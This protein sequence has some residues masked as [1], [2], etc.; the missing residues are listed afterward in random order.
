MNKNIKLVTATASI[1]LAVSL[2]LAGCTGAPATN[3]SPKPSATSSTAPS[4]SP[5]AS[6]APKPGVNPADLKA[7][8][9]VDNSTA[10]D[11]NTSDDRTIH[12]YK[13]PNGSYAV[14]KTAEPLPAAVAADV[15]A[16]ADAAPNVTSGTDSQPNV[17]TAHGL[18]GSIGYATG[19]S[20]AVI[21]Y[22]IVTTYT[23]ETYNGWIGISSLY[24]GKN[25]APRGTSEAAVEAKVRA[26]I[27]GQPNP[28]SWLVVVNH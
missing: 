5:S 24:N 15:V 14:V 16:K 11:I 9:V 20:V 22:G 19:K 10:K 2:A 13:L 25:P 23:G 3:T 12:A 27:A 18:Q 28:D 1:A 8:D 17:T 26:D 6:A 21:Q 4:A 7:G